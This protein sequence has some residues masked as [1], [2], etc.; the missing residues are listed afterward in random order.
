MALRSINLLRCGG[1]VCDF[2]VR[3]RR[4]AGWVQ[5]KDENSWHDWRSGGLIDLNVLTTLGAM[6]WELATGSTHGQPSL[7]TV[8]PLYVNCPNGSGTTVTTLN[9]IN[10]GGYNYF[11]FKG[12]W[13]KAFEGTSS[14]IYF[15]VS[16][17]DFDT[18]EVLYEFTHPKG[19]TSA[20]GEQAFDQIVA[21][22]EPMKTNIQIQFENGMTSTTNHFSVE[23]LFF[24]RNMIN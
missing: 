1:D 2:G 17:L 13:Q 19:G 10:A 22:T 20:K 7:V 14:S 24:S 11:R 23:T 16:L 5:I 18:K 6:D 4:E 3:R 15:K 9:A 21:L 8:N 12:S